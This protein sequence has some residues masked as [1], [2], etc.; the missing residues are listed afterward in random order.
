[1]TWRSVVLPPGACLWDA[2][3][4]RPVEPPDHRV[5]ADALSRA[6]DWLEVE[7]GRW[8]KRE[9]LAAVRRKLEACLV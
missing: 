3:H 8:P 2:R 1:M 5:M 4:P 9:T 6:E 7:H